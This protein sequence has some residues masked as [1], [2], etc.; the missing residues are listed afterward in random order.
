MLSDLAELT[1]RH[2]IVERTIYL[3]GLQAAETYDQLVFTALDSGLT[4]VYR[5][6]GRA[7]DTTLLATDLIGYRDLTELDATLQDQGARPFESGEYVFVCAPQ[8]YSG[9]L[10]DPDSMN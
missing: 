4:T 1:A 6:N 7:G 10:N 9:L 5:P 2:Q 3:L 8:V